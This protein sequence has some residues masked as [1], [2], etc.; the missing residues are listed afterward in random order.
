MIRTQTLIWEA[1]SPPSATLHRGGEWETQFWKHLWSGFLAAFSVIKVYEAIPLCTCAGFADEG[2]T[3]SITLF[4]GLDA[5]RSA[6]SN[7]FLGT[8]G[9]IGDSQPQQRQRR[10][11]NGGDLG[12]GGGLGG[13]S[14]VNPL[15]G[16]PGGGVGG[17]ARTKEEEERETT[18]AAMAAALQRRQELTAAGAH[19]APFRSASPREPIPNGRSARSTDL[20]LVNSVVVLR[21]LIPSLGLRV[22]ASAPSFHY[23]W[24][25]THSLSLQAA[26]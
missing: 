11:L 10:N 15:L 13:A 3:M 7:P 6:P 12:G 24:L 22:K 25:S 17:K 16:A 21:L 23:S 4:F 8:G 14:R 5:Q 9:G 26:L 18:S 20:I 2:R 1:T 19:S